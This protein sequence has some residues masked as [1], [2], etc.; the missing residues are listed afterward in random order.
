[1]IPVAMIAACFAWQA[2]AP[3]VTGALG[4][5]PL[6][7]GV[8]NAGAATGAAP[9]G[10]QGAG[11]GAS[12]SVVPS[13][14]EPMP[15]APIPAAN[16]SN[17]ATA[18]PAAVQDDAA[19]YARDGYG[20]DLSVV[21]LYMTVRRGNAA[22]NTD[23]DWEELSKHSVLEYLAS[24]QNRDRVECILQEGGEDGPEPGRFGYGETTPNGTVQIRGNTSS[25]EHLKSYRIDLKE[26]AGEW[27]GQAVLNLNKHPF[28]AT[29][30]RNKLA[31][32]LLRGIPGQ[33][34]MRTQFV[35]LFVKDE[36]GGGASG[37]YEDYGLFTQVE[38]PNRAYL[39]NHGLDAGGDLYKASMFEYATDEAVRLA[40]DPAYDEAAFETILESKGGV[41]HEKLIE[42]LAEVNDFNIDTKAL[43][44]KRFDAE[45]LFN[46]LAF[47]ILTGNVD[48]SNRNFLLYSPRN[49]EKW[50]YITWDA[51]TMLY[52]QEKYLRY[53][54][55]WNHAGV[56]GDPMG[57]FE[58]IGNE[59]GITNYWLTNLMRRVLAE[60]EYRV[61]LD[62][63]VELV[64][65][66]LSPERVQ[67]LAD[68][69]GSVTGPF[70][71]RAPDNELTA[72]SLKTKYPGL[73][74]SIGEE[75][76]LNYLLYRKSMDGIMPFYVALPEKT[77]R[78][79]AFRWEQS[80]SPHEGAVIRYR[81][82]V[83][84][85]YGFAELV[86]T[87]DGLYDLGVEIAGLALPPGTYFARV[88]ARDEE[89]REQS[90]GE[91]VVDDAYGTHWGVLAFDVGAGGLVTRH[92]SNLYEDATGTVNE[93]GEGGGDA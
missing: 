68:R 28:D 30:F 19:C 16:P 54:N 24:G 58:T 23:T 66:A 47:Q 91:Y 81:L 61:R 86:A 27:R 79:Y 51:D 74:E 6:P 69:Y 32:D 36:T 3:A 82:D 92:S 44:E 65:A 52:R 38:Q 2:G 11:T 15:G 14:Q 90:A 55:D 25:R 21:N 49:S 50:Y 83:A 53:L 45:N 10:S 18:A 37:G 20:D 48:T 57:L 4:A 13:A 34:S 75:V 76:W 60:P 40:S 9:T 93:T 17:S 31:Y 12:A 67:A 5:A 1:M 87:R 85:D 88:V 41:D 35:R 33:I 77:A 84:R 80:V 63:A 78:G 73:N 39:R 72:S 64:R 29:G 43:F 89:G 8:A 71:D 62:Q 59:Y 70:R 7:S 22:E 26:G 46:W 56:Q 42:T